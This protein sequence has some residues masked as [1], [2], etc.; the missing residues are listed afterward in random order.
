MTDPTKP[1]SPPRRT[2]SIAPPSAEYAV[3]HA[4]EQLID[5]LDLL[6]AAGE[7]D[8]LELGIM[9]NDGRVR[10]CFRDAAGIEREFRLPATPKIREIIL[11]AGGDDE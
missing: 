11:R 2:S 3:T 6:Q 10:L 1:S 9:A 7:I 5:A 4:V 8:S